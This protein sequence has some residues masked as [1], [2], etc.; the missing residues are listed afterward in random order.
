MQI[1]TLNFKMQK[2]ALLN[3]GPQYVVCC[4]RH[5]RRIFEPNTNPTQSIAIH[6]K[7]YRCFLYKICIFEP[8]VC[9]RKKNLY[10][11]EKNVHGFSINQHVQTQKILNFPS[12]RHLVPYGFYCVQLRILIV[13]L[14]CGSLCKWLGHA[15]SDCRTP[16]LQSPKFAVRLG[17]I[18]NSLQMIQR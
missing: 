14:Y 12:S 8:Y 9:N 10:C 11:L 5:R 3:G 6:C 1:Y 4:R 15:R 16:V 2:I 7:V 13:F 17:T 18:S